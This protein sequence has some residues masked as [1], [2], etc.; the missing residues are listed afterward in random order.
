M[1][2]P[3][4]LNHRVATLERAAP[5]GYTE[6]NGR[7]YNSRGEWVEWVADRW[8]VVVDGSALGWWR[9]HYDRDGYYE[10]SSRLLRRDHDD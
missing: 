1:E 4:D 5:S 8:M 9:H 3:P 7:T 10:S 2:I 6:R